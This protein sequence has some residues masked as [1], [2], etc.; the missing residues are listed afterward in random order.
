MI[1]KEYYKIFKN[2]KNH[3]L[4]TRTTTSFILRKAKGVLGSYKNN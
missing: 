3:F 1:K 4:Y 2:K